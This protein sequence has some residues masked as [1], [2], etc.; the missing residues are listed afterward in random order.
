MN[1]PRCEERNIEHPTLNAEH[2]IFSPRSAGF[3]AC[4]L[5]ELS[6]SVLDSR[7]G[8]PAPHSAFD[9]RCLALD[10]S[11]FRTVAR[12][13]NLAHA[14]DFLPRPA[15]ERGER[16]GERGCSIRF[17]KVFRSFTSTSPPQPS[18]PFFKWRGGSPCVCQVAPV[19][20]IHHSLMLTCL[21][22]G[23]IKG[24]DEENQSQLF[25]RSAGIAGAPVAFPA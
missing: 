6:S 4:G 16:V 17:H 15:A 20:R 3:P 21:T 1:E 22:V 5:T 11:S 8:K 14:P 7:L 13:R 9:V 12:G 2:R 19:A 25:E 18:P 10:V 23:G 24:A